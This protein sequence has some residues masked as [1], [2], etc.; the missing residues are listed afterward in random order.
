MKT[1]PV[2]LRRAACVLL[3]CAALI[4]GLGSTETPAEASGANSSAVAV[5]TKDGSSLFSLSFSLLNMNGD[6]VDPVNVAVAIASCESCQ[7]VAI[8]IQAV[9]VSST[10]SVVAPVNLA[11]AINEN[12][13]TCQTLASAYQ[14]VLGTGGP[15]RL[16]PA[17]RRRIAAIRRELHALRKS[18]LAIEE[19]QSRTDQLATELQEVL[20]TELVP[21][22]PPSG[23]DEG[24]EVADSPPA[25]EQPAQEEGPT[26]PGQ[27][28]G[29]GTSTAPSGGE[30]AQPD[31]TTA[32][33]D[34]GGQAGTTTDPDPAAQGTEGSSPPPSEQGTSTTESSP[35]P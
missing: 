18:D 33:P 6:V 32:P 14:F 27:G 15:V 16:T 10:P 21:T 5:N 26:D 23:H 17:G 3:A 34:D 2:V 35:A 7:T 11:I 12:C 1:R 31:T 22:G 28:A 24:D 29:D 19:I 30:E 8:A 9:L 25:N 20:G 4:A 13:T